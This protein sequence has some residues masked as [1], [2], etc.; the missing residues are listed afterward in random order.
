MRERRIYW[1]APNAAS[2]V[3]PLAV[4]VLLLAISAAL[5]PKNVPPKVPLLPAM[6]TVF[7]AAAAAPVAVRVKLVPAMDP[8]RL[9][10]LIVPVGAVSSRPSV[11]MFVTDPVTVLLAKST[12]NETAPLWIVPKVEVLMARPVMFPV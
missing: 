5:G 6:F 1:R 2:T 11:T 12:L 9:I 10:L 8:V 7:P 3:M 4:I